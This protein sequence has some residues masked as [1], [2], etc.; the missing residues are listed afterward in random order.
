MS[1]R[2]RLLIA[3][4]VIAVVALLGAG[5]ATYSAFGSYLNGQL[6]STLQA[7]DV[8]IETCL[9]QGGHLTASLVAESVPGIF[10]ELRDRAGRVIAS[11]AASDASRPLGSTFER[12]RLPARI[13]GIA[14]LRRSSPPSGPL[15]DA[16]VDTLGH[17]TGPPASPSTATSSLAADGAHLGQATYLTTA[18]VSSDEPAYRVRASVLANGDVLILG[19]PL[20]ETGN[21]LSRLLLIELGVSGAALL[22][23]LALGV[24]LVRVGLRPLVEVERTAELIMDGDLQARVPD[25]F[26]PRTEMGR[27]T[28]VLNR[29]LARIS[30]EFRERDRTERALRRSESHMRDFLADASHELRTP[31]A[32]ISAYAQLFSR[33]ADS[34]PEDLTRVLSGIQSETARMSRLV[35]DL[36]LLASLDEG[37]PLE[38]R[39]V[40]LVALCASAVKAAAAVGSQW[41][42]DL[43]AAEP[44]EIQGDETR[45]RQVLDNLLSNVR[46]H[47]PPGTRCTIRLLRDGTSASIQVADHGPGLR[48]EARDRVFERF[49]R[50]DPSRTR[51]SGGAGL[52][53]AIVKAI[54]EA[55][56]GSAEVVETPGGGATFLIRLPAALDGAASVPD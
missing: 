43:L 31:I 39:P 23:A 10:A 4:G 55:H 49:F 3:V 22:V 5:V 1:L 17:E 9:N 21:T 30:D 37:L 7:A 26:R 16:C 11:V 54:V 52:G 14:G 42:V 12:P 13:A 33:G 48:P 29:M 27:L 35:T 20:T 47:T 2:L 40:E 44:V 24:F 46:F 19:S 36:M 45:L 25:R 32:A 53:L 15:S 38:R 8:P 50:E 18:A 34:R 41:P 56:G 6:D 51:A 28:E